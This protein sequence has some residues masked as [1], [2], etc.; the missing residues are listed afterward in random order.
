M[1]IP[2]VLVVLPLGL[3][4]L[5]SGLIVNSVQAVLFVSIRPLSKSLYRRINRFL[6]E[7]L[8]L[9]L[10]WLVDWWAGVKCSIAFCL[11]L[12]EIIVSH[13]LFVH[14]FQSFNSN[15]AGT[16]D[17]DQETYQLTGKEHA[18]IISN[19][20]SDIDWLIGWILAQ[21]SGCLGST[22][23]IM[24]KSFKVPSFLRPHCYAW[25]KELFPM[26]IY[27]HPWCQSIKS[28]KEQSSSEQEVIGWSM[29]FAEYLFLERSWAK[30]ENTLKWGLK[31]LQDFPRSF[32]LAL[33]VEGTRFMPAKLLAAQEYAASQGL[34][35]P[36]NV[37]IP[38][39]KG[40]VSAVSI[41]RDFV[42][43]IYDTTVIIPKDSPAPT[44]LR[45][46]KGQSSVVHVRIKRHAMSDMPKSNEDVSKWCTDIFVAKD[47]LLDKHIAIGT[48]D[49]EIRPIGR[50][51]KSL[52]VV[53]S[54]SC[55]LLFGAYRFLQWTQLLSTWKGIILFVAGL[56]LVT[57]IMH[58]FIMF[59]QSERSS[60]ARA[61]RNQVKK[62]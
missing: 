33:F 40:F 19:H 11:D 34:P 45:I 29:W 9:Q 23:A 59:S 26:N 37:L 14:S 50:P 46:L 1:A 31:R 51:I 57:G 62:G 61:A 35:A 7:L 2:L 39:T 24:K 36:R 12:S 18:L 21:R 41:M 3:L 30:D 43:A 13:S 56:G 49:E 22:L 20:R 10:I 8:W 55:L 58:V 44:M 47:A 27:D 5:L 48:F 17:A 53:L 25:V 6:A 38:R 42:P 32:W 16:I 52:L 15:S 60:S 4:F 28:I 54:W